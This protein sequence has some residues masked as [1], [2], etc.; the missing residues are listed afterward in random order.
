MKNKRL[1][2]SLIVIAAL[3]IIS[4][5]VY[6]S[7]LRFD[8]TLEFQVGD[9]VSKAWAWDCTMKLQNRIIK[10][11]YQSD[12]GLITY[13]FT[14]LEPGDY[15][16]KLVAPS[17]VP[18]TVPVNLKRG[19]NV[20]EKPIELV[21]YE[22]PDLD[23]FTIFE[24]LDGTDIVQEIRPVSSKGPAV[25]NH[26]CID[27]WI[28]AQ[29]SV[30]VKEGMAVLVPTKEGAERGKLLFRGKIDWAWDPLPETTFRYSSRIPGSQIKEHSSPYRV[31][32]Y[33][34]VV[35]DPRK[36]EPEELDVLMAEAWNFREEKE[37]AAFLD[38]Y[39]STL[40]YFIK[41][42]WNVESGT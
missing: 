29:V 7:S 38:Q 6:L 26:P 27:L 20:V 32:D 31:I 16:L 25:I 4:F 9:A 18:K 5:A 8:T 42:N 14:H 13:R 41:T 12:A 28:A 30:Q 24:E 17:Y 33:L 37:I 21:G 34:I 10:G 35:P 23:Y 39:N 2:I 36:I 40:K 22:I 11:Y 1:W 15:E 19:E 3:F